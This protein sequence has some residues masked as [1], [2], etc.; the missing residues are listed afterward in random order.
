MMG[1]RATGTG[2]KLLAGV[3][4]AGVL[5]GCSGSGMGGFQNEM[6]QQAGRAL[7]GQLFGQ[8]GDGGTGPAGWGAGGEA[9]AGEIFTYDQQ[10]GGTLVSSYP[11]TIREA[12]LDWF[13]QGVV[14]ADR[15]QH[16]L[17]VQAPRSSD[18][19]I[20]A[21]TL[22][23]AAGTTAVN[24]RR[25]DVQACESDAGCAYL[26]RAVGPV[27]PGQLQALSTTGGS[28]SLAFA[29]GTGATVSVAAAE[30]EAYLDAVAQAGEAD[31]AS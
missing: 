14:G 7:G 15:R 9:Q 29:D 19:P 30:I 12:R 4:L 24:L 25:S 2:A 31:T 3:A 17:F 22:R 27:T 11:Y 13:L 6:G 18:T 21:V 10:R 20:E 8:D 28:M 26:A 23:D 5:A 16:H 1:H